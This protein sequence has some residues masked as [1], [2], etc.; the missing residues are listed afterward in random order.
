MKIVLLVLSLMLSVLVHAE[1][2]PGSVVPA[3][4][5]ADQT[6]KTRASDE[7]RGKWLVLYFYPKAGT[8]GCTEEACSFRDD[9][10]VLRALGAEVLGVST[11]SV[12]AI[13]SFGKQHE[14]PFTLLADTDGKVAEQ[15][16]A[17]MNLGVAKFAK[18]Y[19]YLI[20]P[21]G[22]LVKFYKDVDTKTYAK[23][24]AADLRSLTARKD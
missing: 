20:D 19:T 11:D 1:L 5:L 4:S 13:R 15:Y 22:R 7:F 3:F 12:E 8:P 10:V 6:G 2:L 9:I 21:A 23:T 18:R 17:L 14:L 16:G 24:I